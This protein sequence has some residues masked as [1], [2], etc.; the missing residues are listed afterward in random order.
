MVSALKALAL[1]HPSPSPGRDSAGDAAEHTQCMPAPAAR[2][3]VLRPAGPSALSEPVVVTQ[4]PFVLGRDSPP[5][6]DA[7]QRF[8]SRQHACLVLRG[9]QPH[10]M[11]LASTNGT[12]VDGDK[13]LALEERLLRDGGTVSFGS[14]ALAFTV[15]LEQGFA[16][17][18]LGSEPAKEESAPTADADGFPGTLYIQAGRPFL[19]A[20][21]EHKHG[22]DGEGADAPDGSPGGS[23]QGSQ[24]GKQALSTRTGRPPRWRKAAV[25]VTEL[26]RA[27]VDDQA[28][29]SRRI[30]LVP[31]LMGAVLAVAV[32]GYLHQAPEREIRVLIKAGD[33]QQAIQ[34]A[35][36]Y[37]Q[38]DP[39][40]TGVVALAEEALVRHLVPTWQRDLAQ[41]R[42]SVARAELAAAVEPHRGQVEGAGV[43][44]LLH[45]VTDLDEFWSHRGGSEA[46]IQLFD[47]EIAMANLL[48]RWNQNGA[49]F[50]HLLVWIQNQVPAFDRVHVHTLSQLR[51]LRNEGSVHLE[52]IA[53]LKTTIAKR[54]AAD[55]VA[56]LKP[57]LQSFGQ[58]YPRVRGLD[59]LQ[60][61][62]D[63]LLAIREKV[64][65][66]DLAAL[67]SA[68]G[69][70]FQTPV[71]AEHGSLW[72][73]SHLPPK[74]LLAAYDQAR[75]HWLAGHTNEAIA[76]LAQIDDP[77]WGQVIA[78]K[79][80]HYRA[81]AAGYAALRVGVPAARSRDRILGF[82]RS[83]DPSEDRYYLQM[84][85]DQVE[86]Q[87]DS[88]LA[89][90]R[91]LFAQAREHWQSYRSAGAISGLM[92]LESTLTETFQERTQ[93]MAEAFRCAALAG[94]LY[95]LLGLEPAADEQ[96]LFV[97]V[98][99]EVS[100]QRQWL[101]DLHLV[102]DPALLEQKLELMPT[103]EESLS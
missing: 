51:V 98:V 66:Q 84:I 52:A 14:P 42:Y 65:V 64:A 1:P 47:H 50:H 26:K 59:G 2:R 25:F 8:L 54:V 45:W 48:Q 23:G 40:D 49:A 10:L 90:A 41:R 18:G 81:V 91:Q 46:P 15:H 38:G 28:R 70:R 32:G 96:S 88:A 31:G 53:K 75:Q 4:F 16:P 89:E 29:R 82:H 33:Y 7:P 61:D 69:H 44:E 5:A 37:L 76:I 103:I 85:K 57:V 99:T 67:V 73:Q 30:W 43:K 101:Q 74:A 72:L 20:L 34:R 77:H 71:F 95:T 35:N 11:D 24:S 80:E 87:R 17:T 79:L 22:A 55:Q 68:H 13:L 39:D 62:L 36:G 93:Q 86:A 9:G 94:R 56:E 78:D 19:D 60:A 102:L 12:W 21:C 63:A 83:L 58:T 27:F 97:N 100:R 6:A 3:L 92:R